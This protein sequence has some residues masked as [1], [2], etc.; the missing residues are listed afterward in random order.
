MCKGW[1]RRSG[2]IR[3]VLELEGGREYKRE[4]APRL[5]PSSPSL[6]H[7]S[8]PHL[9]ISA[10]V[11]LPHHYISPSSLPSALRLRCCLLRFGAVVVAH[12]ELAGPMVSPPLVAH[13]TSADLVFPPVAASLSNHLPYRCRCVQ[14]ACARRKPSLRRRTLACSLITTSPLGLFSDLG[15]SAA[16]PH[17]AC[18]LRFSC[19]S[20]ALSF[21]AHRRHHFPSS[22]FLARRRGRRLWHMCV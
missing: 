22:T 16:L 2:S 7:F 8:F 1:R 15:C 6:L 13:H 21:H 19:S 10:F 17:I 9:S 4:D 14:T 11:S 3:R 12:S 20:L 5:Y 18:T